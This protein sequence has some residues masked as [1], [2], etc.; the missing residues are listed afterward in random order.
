MY[1]FF[2]QWFSNTNFSFS[3]QKSNVPIYRPSKNNCWNLHVANTL[4]EKSD[5]DKNKFVEIS[6]LK[7]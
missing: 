5:C 1:Q 3:P 7:D 6:I 4:A 2:K